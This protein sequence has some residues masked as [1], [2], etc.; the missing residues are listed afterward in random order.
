MWC[1]KDNSRAEKEVQVIGEKSHTILR[2]SAGGSVGDPGPD[3]NVLDL[4][5]PDPLVKGTDPDPSLFS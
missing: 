3:P 5:D 2:S 4:P 1:G